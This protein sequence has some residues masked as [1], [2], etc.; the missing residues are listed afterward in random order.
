VTLPH[1]LTFDA[2]L[3][4][5]DGTLIDSEP[6]WFDVTR[7]VA[8]R[9]GCALPDGAHAALHGQDRATSTR[10]LQGYGLAGDLNAFWAA[11][12]ERLATALAAVKPMPNADAWVEAVVQGGRA[13]ALVSN[14]PR[15]MIDASLA[16]QA[17]GH[18]LQ[19]RIGIEDVP[20]GKP[21]PHGYLLAAARLGVD[22]H[23]CLVIE[24]SLAGARAGVAA[25]AT[26]LFVTNGVIDPAVAA[27]ITPHVTAALPSL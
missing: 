18:H 11:V 17:W 22:I 14:S 10:I 16:P 27:E 8:L 6:I 1:P 7:D 24:D 9:F 3:F 25:G 20:R 2:V 21:E 15:A 12:V 19:V 5:M 26:T 4:D 13:R 23:R